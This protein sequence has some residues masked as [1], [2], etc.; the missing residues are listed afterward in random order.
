MRLT[1]LI[2]LG[3]CLSGLGTFD[4]SA[5]SNTVTNGGEAIG[6]GGTVSY[7]IGQLDYV[8]ATASSGTLTQ[9]VQ[10]PYEILLVTEIEEASI[11]SSISIYPNPTHDLIILKV[12]GNNIES[13][14]YQLYDIQ[15]KLLLI[16]EATGEQTTILMNE[17]VNGIY[18]IKIIDNDTIIKS[19]KIIKNK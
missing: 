10:Q 4:L 6:G 16:K 2:I 18:I 5:Q 3:L 11:H 17:F 1:K 15:G 14:S 7:S 9:G 19:V 8:T 13:I 12:E